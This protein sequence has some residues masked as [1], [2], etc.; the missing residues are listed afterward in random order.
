[1]VSE[2]Y[3]QAGIPINWHPAL[4]RAVRKPL[5]GELVVNREF[6]GD[7]SDGNTVRIVMTSDAD[8]SDYDRNA[9]YTSNA[10]PLADQSLLADQQKIVRFR[11]N[12]LD[13]KQVK[14]NFVDEQAAR[15][16]YNL[17]R[18]QDAF[19]FQGYYDGVAAA[20][21]LGAYTVS[22]VDADAFELASYAAR[23][24]DDNETPEDMGVPGMDQEGGP[25]GG[26]RFLVVPPLY[27]EQ[28][29]ND[30]RRSSFGTTDNLR[31]YGERY[32][33]RSVA[34]LEIF[35]STNL[36]SGTNTT[37]GAGYTGV[38]AGWT[39]AGAFASQFVKFETQ[40]IVGA[41]ADLHLGV[42]VYGFKEVYPNNVVTFDVRAA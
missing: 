1:M 13:I 7:L 30:P 35:K 11:V 14:P 32:I 9:T 24:L 17:K 39:K 42:Q 34:G 29:V 6:E 18:V 10:L 22:P 40:R 38:V 37:A 26:F 3:Q 41:L 31:T 21:Y 8:V 16:V 2:S 12:D 15:A 25:D 23:V 27:A 20:N 36:P 19:I 28:L 5:V 4:L 33:G